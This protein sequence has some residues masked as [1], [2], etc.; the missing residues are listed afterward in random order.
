MK[1]ARSPAHRR[2]AGR[3]VG[4]GKSMLAHKVMLDW[5]DGKLFQDRFD[6]ACYI[7]CREMNR[8]TAERSA[9]DPPGRLLA[10]ALRSPGARARVL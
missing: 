1:S 7:N 10:G 9:R 6:Y 2:P 3:G 8:G 4:M 5:A